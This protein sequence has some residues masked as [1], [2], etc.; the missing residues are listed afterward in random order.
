MITTSVSGMFMGFP[1]LKEVRMP[2][3]VIGADGSAPFSVC[4]PILIEAVNW[5]IKQTQLF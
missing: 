5:P 3:F 2:F 1:V 4:A